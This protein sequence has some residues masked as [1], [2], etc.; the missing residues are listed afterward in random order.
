MS[1]RS[2]FPGQ[3]PPEGQVILRHV[4][5]LLLLVLDGI[6]P[7]C[8][9]QRIGCAMHDDLAMSPTDSPSGQFDCATAG[10][11]ESDP[12]I[13]PEGHHSNLSAKP[14]RRSGSSSPRRPCRR[15]RP[16]WA[17]FLAISEPNTT[18]LCLA[19]RPRVGPAGRGA[20]TPNSCI[21][22]SFTRCDTRLACPDQS[23]PLAC[24]ARLG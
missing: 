23:R 1:P 24:C 9:V 6:S 13:V 12:S 11:V 4:L 10:V 18:Y 21:E 22:T 5:L 8:A 17:E 14:T 19:L 7:L 16:S 20:K 15:V 2:G 3:G